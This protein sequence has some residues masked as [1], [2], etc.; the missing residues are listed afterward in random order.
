MQPEI[1][2]VGLA[3][4]DH[5]MIV[6][7]FPSRE[8]VISSTQYEVHGGGMVS[9]ALVAA[10]RLGG[11]TEFW[12]R[13][14]DD[15]Y[16]ET[17]IKELKQYGVGTNQIYVVANGRTGV[18]FVLVKAGTGE[19]SF[20]IHRQKN[21]HVDLKTLNL[22]RI[23]K[24]KVLLIDA[25]WPEAA[26]KA[27]HFAKAHGVPV[28]CDVHDP[29]QPSLDLLALSD[30]AVVP[31][32]LADV[33]A[34]KGDYASALHDL[35]SRGVKVPII[36]LGKDGC[37][38]LF[39]GRVYKHPSFPVKVL[40]TT[41]AG[42]CFHGAFCFGLSRNLELPQSVTFASA[43]AALSTTKLG[44]RA[45]IPTYQETIAFMQRQGELA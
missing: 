7:E 43:V 3:V 24:A 39:Q 5:L 29:T 37:T 32:H 30:Y 40:D 18:C 33:L 10:A 28:I 12:G 19:R 1:I 25:S 36:T 26:H 14:G 34:P 16:G 15:E 9:T 2:G 4:L 44:G 11:S 41:G 35:K 21:L 17:I 22:E 23:K 20:V 6:P 8:G 27:A 42:D 38:Y 13:V 45:G 31:R